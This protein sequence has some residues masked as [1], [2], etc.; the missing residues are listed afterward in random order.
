RSPVHRPAPHPQAAPP[1][2]GNRTSRSSPPARDTRRPATPS[3]EPEQDG[4]S[5]PPTSR[6]RSL[7]RVLDS[8]EAIAYR[9]AKRPRVDDRKAPLY[10]YLHGARGSIRC[11][12]Y[13]LFNNVD[14]IFMQG[15][16]EAGLELEKDAEADAEAKEASLDAETRS[17]LESQR[18]VAFSGLR[19]AM[20]G[21]LELLTECVPHP[22]MYVAF[23]DM[24][25]TVINEAKNDDTGSLK[26]DII[27]FVL[28]DPDNEV[29]PIPYSDVGNKSKRGFSID[30]F[31]RCLI[32]RKL[33]DSMDE[34]YDACVASVNDGTLKVDNTS[35]PMLLYDWSSMDDDD[36][37][38]GLFRHI[39]LVRSWR[40]IMFGKSNAL[41]TPKSVPAGSN[42]HIHNVLQAS[43]ASIAYVCCQVR[44][45]MSSVHTWAR[46]D[47]HF[48]MKK[49]YD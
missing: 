25:K 31:A 38:A 5:P 17:R 26:Q 19:D 12:P 13:I 49:F 36:S 27:K 44:F 29:A 16:H 34:D 9:G 20:P 48:D 2:G 30:V 18:S 42:A 47:R 40:R 7:D 6:K 10:P 24:I 39:A 35:L 28:E 3:P 32:S 37:E 21:L 11:V 15:I 46:M 45:A 43:P 14:A 1:S 23:C 41:N 33:Y 22:P 4:D 8:L